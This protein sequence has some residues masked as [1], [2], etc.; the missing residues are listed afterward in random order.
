MIRARTDFT[1]A[2]LFVVRCPALKRLS[3]VLGSVGLLAGCGQILGL[4]DYE[5]VDDVTTTS[6]GGAGGAGGVGGSAGG[7]GGSAGATDGGSG[8]TGGAGTTAS[9][10]TD[11]GGTGADGG[12]GGS[13]STTMGSGGS[14]GAGPCDCDERNPCLTSECDENGMCVPKALGTECLSGNFSGVCDDEQQCVPCVDDAEDFEV[15][16]GCPE[17][18][19]QCDDGGDVPECTGCTENEDCDDGVSCTADT[20]DDGRCLR[21]LLPAGAECPDGVCNGGGA[22]NSC[23]PCVDNQATGLDAGCEAAL[24]LCDATQ[25]PAVCVECLA[26][27]DCDDDN[28]CTTETCSSKLCVLQTVPAG[29]ECVGGVCSGVAGSESCGVCLDTVTGDGVD[30]GCTEGA[31]VCDMAQVPPACTG[32]TTH[33]DCDDGFECTT[34]TCNESQVC[35]YET[36]DGLCEASGDACLA[37]QCVAGSGCTLVDATQQQQLLADGSFD[38]ASNVWGEYSAVFGGVIVE[39]GYYGDWLADTPTRFVWMGGAYEESSEVWQ[40]VIVPE[41]AQSL[42]VSFAYHVASDDMPYLP[43]YNTMGAELR[44]GDGTTVHHVFQTLGNQD[45]NAD[46]TVFT[47]TIDATA[48]A[49]TEVRLY[50]WAE[51]QSQPYCYTYGSYPYYYED[52]LDIGLTSYMIDTVSL[53]ATVCE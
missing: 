15:D 26:A 18:A 28:E 12:A 23:V 9:G 17:T 13:T 45:T 3:F 50:F 10:G 42:T 14:A 11:T 27:A 39:E 33:D 24:P 52:C 5:E 29:E 34:D 7:S 20:C 16:S 51:V 53:T 1:G 38:S 40:N 44:S 30:Q 41:G 37:N 31:P 47:E 36:D 46:W 21:A 49:G 4:G 19:P 2:I 32:C 25:S 6:G 8:G 22:S 48:L 43:D 35:V